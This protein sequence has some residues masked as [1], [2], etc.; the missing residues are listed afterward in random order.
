MV[1]KKLI[2]INCD[3]YIFWAYGLRVIFRNMEK[4]YLNIFCWVVLKNLFL[5]PNNFNKHEI[6]LFFKSK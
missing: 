5:M 2:E 4:Y 3:F 1:D 6:F